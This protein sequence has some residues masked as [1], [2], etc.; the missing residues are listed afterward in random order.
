MGTKRS[1][2]VAQKSNFLVTNIS[3]SPGEAVLD[4]SAKRF[5]TQFAVNLQQDTDSGEVKLYVL[6]LARDERTEKRQWI[7]SA[8]RGQA[9]ADF[10][11]DILPSHLECPV[12]SWGAGPGGCWVTPDS[13]VSKQSQILI[14]ILR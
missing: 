13:P 9:V 10:L 5:L 1:E 8:R 12:Y 6:S 4:E 11:D 3:F 14:A 7:S 2:I